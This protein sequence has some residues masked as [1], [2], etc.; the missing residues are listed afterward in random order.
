[1]KPARLAVSFLM[2]YF[3]YAMIEILVR[4]YTHWTMA[5]TG[6]IVLS[7]LYILFTETPPIPLP[8][9]YLFGALTVTAVELAVGVIVNLALRWEVWD[10][11]D[12]PFHL[13]GQICPLYSVYWYFLCI[14]ARLLCLRIDRWFCR[15]K[16]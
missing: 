3:L 13:F 11:S 14:P 6:G 10:Y 1:M 12:R 9:Q 2:G 4:G 7:L 16:A 8:L 15:H 5:L